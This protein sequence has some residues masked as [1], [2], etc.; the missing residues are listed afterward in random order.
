MLRHKAKVI[1]PT[2]IN[3][4]QSV[5]GTEEI[6]LERCLIQRSDRI[7]VSKENTEVTLPATLYVDAHIT[8]PHIDWEM[9]K[10]FADTVNAP[11]KVLFGG[12]RYTV[13]SVEEY[14]DD[15]ARVHHYEVGLT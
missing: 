3:S 4:S 14:L 1:V 10:H 9:K 11:I 15:H 6:T 5:T 13:F 12:K 7:K 8:R 2:Q